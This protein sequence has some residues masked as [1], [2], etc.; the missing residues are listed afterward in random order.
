MK[1]QKSNLTKKKRTKREWLEDIIVILAI[2]T[3]VGGIL[4]YAHYD[5][6]RIVNG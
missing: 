6:A 3:V 4:L 1:R 2:I 5:I